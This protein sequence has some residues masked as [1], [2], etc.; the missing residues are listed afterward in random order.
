MNEF[1]VEEV[2]ADFDKEDLEGVYQQGFR[3][4]N[5][6]VQYNWQDVKITEDTEL[7]EFQDLVREACW[8][9]EDN[10]RQYSPFEFTAKIFNDAGNSEEV[11]EKYEEGIS[12]GI[13]D[14]IKSTCD[15][16]ALYD[17]K[18]HNREV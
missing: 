1:N 9:A 13:E 11:W 6:F 17:M 8:E 4:G 12:D 3:L 15:E 2:G 14:A 10:F 16:V 5:D 18:D 7:D